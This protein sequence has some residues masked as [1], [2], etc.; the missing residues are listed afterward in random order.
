ML[1]LRRKNQTKSVDRE[2]EVC[3]SW[4]EKILKYS[5]TYETYRHESHFAVL[6]GLRAISVLMVIF[7][8][9]GGESF[10]WLSGWLGVHVFFVISGFLITTLLLREFEDNGNVSLKKFYT[11]RFFRITPVYYFVLL[12]VFLQTYATGGEGWEQLKHALPYYL[13]FFNELQFQ[14]PWKITWTMGIEWKFYLVW[15]VLLFL[16]PTTYKR[17]WLTM[18][19]AWVVLVL[20]WDPKVNYAVHYMVLLLGAAVAML[21]HDKRIFNLLRWFMNPFAGIALLACVIVMQVYVIHI[22]RIAGVYGFGRG[23]L[24]YGMLV[25]AFFPTLMGGGHF[26]R[27]LSSDFLAAIGK[28]SYSLYLVQYLAWQAVN[29]LMPSITVS[30]MGAILTSLVGLIFA[31]CLYRWV[32]RPMISVGKRISKGSDAPQ[33]ASSYR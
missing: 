10:K 6:D 16:I 26:N 15:P 2:S 8:H 33:S 14:A 5:P 17:M 12:I 4:K 13:S 32:E 22:E 27:F 23:V 3:S 21:L 28:R 31:D 18:V 11:R 1:F 20:N 29:G 19:V 7:G 24:L 9:F 25:A 30:A